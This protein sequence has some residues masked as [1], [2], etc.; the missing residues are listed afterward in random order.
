VA[1][2][3]T[4][5]ELTR[6]PWASRIGDYV[7][8]G[9]LRTMA[10]LIGLGGLAVLLLGCIVSLAAAENI[11]NAVTMSHWATAAGVYGS[12]ALSAMGAVLGA[13]TLVQWLMRRGSITPL[14]WSIGAFV[15][16]LVIVYLIKPLIH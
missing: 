7:P 8:V 11:R 1:R 2:P 12:I 13:V 4:S 6:Y 15:P 16:L 9:R 5:D 10:V 14:V 3:L